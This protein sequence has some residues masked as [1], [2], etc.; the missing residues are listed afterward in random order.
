MSS[1]W[2]YGDILRRAKSLKPLVYQYVMYIGP[3]DGLI[4]SRFTGIRLTTDG[5]E[6]ATRQGH[7]GHLFVRLYFELAPEEEL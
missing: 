3:G 6:A 4:A 2:K 5:M 7:I 1:E